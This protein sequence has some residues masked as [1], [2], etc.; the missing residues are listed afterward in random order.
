MGN[1]D[2]FKSS[3]VSKKSKKVTKDITKVSS[4]KRK[5]TDEITKKTHKKV[6]SPQSKSNATKVV[7]S[8]EK[9]QEIEYESSSPSADESEETD[10]QTNALLRGFQSDEEEGESLDDSTTPH[11]TLPTRKEVSKHQEKILNDIAK[12]STHE[13]PGVVYVGRIPH[14]FYENEMRGYFK[15]FGTISKLRLS[16]NKKTGASKHYAWIKFASATVAEIVAKT[17]DNYL[18]FGHLLKVKLVPD[19][20]VPEALFKGANKRFKKIPW[21]KIEGRRLAQPTSEEVWKVRIKREE[22]RRQE[23]AE[24][25]KKIG[26][27]FESPQIKSICT[28]QRE[29]VT[30]PGIDVNGG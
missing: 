12:S 14:G 4:M 21:N 20:Q 19:E 13:K 15:Q 3:E 23:K 9:T 17:M 18:M 2:S 26:Y 1:T 22:K 16:R 11:L 7:K 10:D 24:K 6:S 30:S 28:I 27:E 29:E 25:L 8:S 5:A